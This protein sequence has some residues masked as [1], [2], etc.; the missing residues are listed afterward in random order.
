MVKHAIPDRP[1]QKLACDILTLDGKDFI[2]TVDYYS[3]YFKIDKFQGK[4]DTSTVVKVLKRH[5]AT[6]GI[7][8]K[9][10]TDNGPP[11]NTQN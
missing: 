3:D 9:I 6:Q 1:W 10:F 2:V 11:F 5:F 4:K 7:S 8:D